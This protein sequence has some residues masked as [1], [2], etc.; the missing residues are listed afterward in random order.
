SLVPNTQCF[1]ASGLLHFTQFCNCHEVSKDLWMPASSELLAAFLANVATHQVSYDCAKNWMSGLHFWHSCHGAPWNG[2]TSQV[3]IVHKGVKKLV[4]ATSQ[5]PPRVPVT[6]QHMYTL[7]QHLSTSNSKDVALL[8][9]AEATFWGTCRLGETTPPSMWL[10]D[11][12]YHVMKGT[13]VSDKATRNGVSY[14]MFQIPWSKTTG[15]Q[16]T[17]IVLTAQD[18]FSNPTQSF[19]WHR[20]VNASVP[21]DAPLFMHTT[22]SGGWEGWTRC[23][24]LS[25]FNEIWSQVGLESMLEHSFWI[26]NTTELLFQGISPDIVAAQG[27][28]KS[29][30]SF[31]WY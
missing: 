22:D 15:F 14:T 5:C 31:L 21:D 7:Q 20:M 23:D 28:W 27:C 3:D 10:F 26:G 19:A 13:L 4:P 25:A 17:D 9:L 2:K 24:M 30:A 29:Q 16:G 1:Y 6:M 11:P 18:D 8:A 12:K